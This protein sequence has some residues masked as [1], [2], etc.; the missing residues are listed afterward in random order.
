V[1]LIT[2]TLPSQR[3]ARYVIPAMPA[4]A[5]LLALFWREIP[6]RWF[7]PTL[8]MAG[9]AL[10]VLTRIAWVAHQLGLASDAEFALALMAAGL[11]VITLAGS[12]VKPAWTRAGAVLACLL[13]YATFE[14]TVA[15]MDGPAGQ[16]AVNASASLGPRARIAVPNGFNGQF[17]RFQF[18]LPGRHQF[19]PYDTEGRALARAAPG[20]TLPAPGQELA[21]LLATHNAVIWVQSSMDETTPSCL[22]DCSVLGERWQLKSRHQSGEVTL[23]NLWQP[24]EWLFRR[25]WLVARATQR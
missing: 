24:Q 16:Y 10:L 5:I 7:L 8:P 11:G 6:R 20:A 18:L 13:V 3:S 15:P 17:E 2:F 1:W 9:L 14:L 21:Q 19:V 12:L 22:P 23:A 4:V 25:E